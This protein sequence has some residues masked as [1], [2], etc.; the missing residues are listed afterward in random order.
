[1]GDFNRF[2]QFL[3]R[4]MFFF[5]LRAGILVG[6]KELNGPHNKGSMLGNMFSEEAKKPQIPLLV[7]C[8]FLSISKSAL[9]H[10]PICGTEKKP[11]IVHRHAKKSTPP[12]NPSLVELYWVLGWDVA[13][14]LLI[15]TENEKGCHA[16]APFPRVTA[17]LTYSEQLLVR[18]GI[19]EIA[20]S[21]LWKMRKSL[22]GL[23]LEV[24]VK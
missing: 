11:L 8:R 6:M 20:R 12:L 14:C 4:T 24:K 17:I 9:V 5:F 15:M 7:K 3:S 2:L 1:M 21:T 19:L 23:F 10:Q 22:L 13:H 16:W 18:T